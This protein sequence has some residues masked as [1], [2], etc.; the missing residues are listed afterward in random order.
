[1]PKLRCRIDRQEM[2]FTKEQIAWLKAHG[3]LFAFLSS[4]GTLFD[5]IEGEESERKNK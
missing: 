4:H 2:E 5:I 1:M 3:M